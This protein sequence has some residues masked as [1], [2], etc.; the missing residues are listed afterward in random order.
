MRNLKPGKGDREHQRGERSFSRSGQGTGQGYRTLEGSLEGSRG[1]V[2]HTGQASPFQAEGT[3]EAG[4]T[5]GYPGTAKK[6]RETNE[7]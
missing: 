7:E 5:L 6:T 1:P 3:A 2:T 4:G